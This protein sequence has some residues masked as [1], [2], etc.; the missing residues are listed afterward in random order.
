MW[1][2]TTVETKILLL[3]SQKAAK[4]TSGYDSSECA[5]WQRS[6]R[7]AVYPIIVEIVT[8]RIREMIPNFA[9]S[10]GKRK[11]PVPIKFSMH[12]STVQSVVFLPLSMNTIG[13]TGD[14]SVD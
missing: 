8:I 12:L 14:P 6:R 13:V 3:R 2:Y 10:S 1:K 9:N 11:T 5:R 7:E 4:M